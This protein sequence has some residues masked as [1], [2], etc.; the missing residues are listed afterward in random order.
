MSLPLLNIFAT[1][2]P[3][4]KVEV[5]AHYYQ[6][7]P[8][9]TLQAPRHFQSNNMASF[10]Y[11]TVFETL[12]LESISSSQRQKEKNGERGLPLSEVF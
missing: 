4:A 11:F 6:P 7:F 10:F 3:L 1:H 5:G 8:Q 2:I 12:H 9:L